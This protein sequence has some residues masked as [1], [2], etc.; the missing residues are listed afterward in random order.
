MTCI[1]QHNTPHTHTHTHTHTHK[2][3]IKTQHKFLYMSIHNSI[4]YN[5]QD[6]RNHGCHKAQVHQ[7][8]NDKQKLVYAYNGLVYNHKQE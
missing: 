4:I 5:T 3:V 8:I 7:L 2:L 1:M 6:F